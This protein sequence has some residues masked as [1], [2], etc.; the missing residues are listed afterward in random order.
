MPAASSLQPERS[1]PRVHRRD[2]RTQ[3]AEADAEQDGKPIFVEQGLQESGGD[4]SQPPP[5]PR[6][7][8]RAAVTGSRCRRQ[9][10]QPPTIDPPTPGRSCTRPMRPSRS[11]QVEHEVVGV[12]DRHHRA[13]PGLVVRELDPEPHPMSR[14]WGISFSASAARFE[15]VLGRFRLALVVEEALVARGERNLRRPPVDR[16]R[17]DHD[18]DDRRR[19]RPAPPGR[20]GPTGLKAAQRALPVPDD[21]AR[22]APPGP[23]RRG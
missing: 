10:R 12:G 15:P 4:E 14:C 18:G 19:R 23:P 2:A 6:P 11:Q 22:R 1:R 21:D 8:A 17:H 16:G 13:G 3:E 7:D 9:T 5:P 20:P